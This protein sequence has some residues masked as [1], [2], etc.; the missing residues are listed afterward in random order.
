MQHSHLLQTLL[1]N[2]RPSTQ[3]FPAP[4]TAQ[5]THT[6]TARYA[7]TWLHIQKNRSSSPGS[8]RH[9]AISTAHRVEKISR[10]RLV[11]V[12]QSHRERSTEPSDRHLVE[13]LDSWNRKDLESAANAKS[14]Q[15][16]EF[17]L[18]NRMKYNEVDH[19]ILDRKSRSVL[20]APLVHRSQSAASFKHVQEITLKRMQ[21]RA[22]LEEQATESKNARRYEEEMLAN[23]NI[24]R[25]RVEQAHSQREALRKEVTELRTRLERAETDMEIVRKYYQ[26]EDSKEKKKIRNLRPEDLARVL[27]RKSVIQNELLLR[28]KEHTETVSHMRVT[29][30]DKSDLAR[31]TDLEVVELRLQLHAAIASQVK[32]YRKLLT[33]GSD[34]RTEG[35]GWIVKRLWSLGEDVLPE[36][37]PGFLDAGAVDCIL[38]LSQK[39]LELEEMRDYLASLQPNS[40]NDNPT[41]SHFDRWNNIRERLK[42][43]TKSLRLKKPLFRYDKRLKQTIVTWEPVEADEAHGELRYTGTKEMFNEA[44]EAGKVREQVE[45]IIQQ[46]QDAEVKRLTHECFLNNYERKYKVSMEDLLSAVLGKETIDHYIPLI[47]KDRKALHSQLAR[48]HTFAFTRC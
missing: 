11:L 30:R 20:P 7:L 32:H 39:H 21:R 45:Q 38:F 22:V 37:F 41:L 6:G 28:E 44:M 14:I 10:K 16:A 27:S 35:L 17:A 48:S 8:P 31:R 5:T 18:N 9:K 33:D 25:N 43:L 19:F 42:H 26:A 4:D 15:E 36:H 12:S 46:T 24:L 2:N 1:K 40:S 34:A 47:E 13:S 23:T 29:V 3:F